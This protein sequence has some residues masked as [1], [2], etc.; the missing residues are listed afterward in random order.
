M[1]NTKKNRIA[2]LLCAALLVSMLTACSA[3]AADPKPIQAVAA[4]MPSPE[5][6]PEATQEAPAEE[7]APVETAAAAPDPADMYK[8]GMQLGSSPYKLTGIAGFKKNGSIKADAEEGFIGYYENEDGL[9]VDIYEFPR[10]GQSLEAYTSLEVEQYSGYDVKSREINGVTVM[11]YMC[12]EEDDAAPGEFYTT[13]NFLFVHFDS[14]V[15]LVF[16]LE[17]DDPA[18]AEALMANLTPLEPKPISLGAT[19]Y[20]LTVHEFFEDRF[21]PTEVFPDKEHIAYY[22]YS[23][24]LSIDGFAVSAEQVAGRSLAD[25]AKD[26]ATKL[27]NGSSRA[28]EIN[29][30]PYACY[31]GIAV[32]PNGKSYDSEIYVVEDG[33][34][35]LEI[36]FAKF[37]IVGDRQVDDIMATLTK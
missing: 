31:E 28:Y 15:E 3:R 13:A 9:G 21:D 30:I 29:G 32:Y 22:H 8:D 2:L 6:S 24:G 35:F 16:W 17:D 1:K 25:Y 26:E 20:Q 19:P 33:D 36:C 5:A 10:E 7:S 37:S 4:A 34:G 11:S 27:L 14:F 12:R 23:R 18:P